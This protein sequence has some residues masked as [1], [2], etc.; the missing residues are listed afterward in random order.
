MKKF[1]LTLSSVALLATMNSCT[2]EEIIEDATP[3]VNDEALISFSDPVTISHGD[4][5]AEIDGTSLPTGGTLGIFAEKTA[6]ES[7]YITNKTLNGYATAT[8]SE[9]TGTPAYY[10]WPGSESLDFYAYFY[11]A[12]SSGITVTSATD[13]SYTLQSTWANQVDLLYTEKVTANRTTGS[14]VPLAFKHTMAW[15]RFNIKSSTNVGAVLNSVSFSADE[16]ATFSLKT[17]TFGTPENSVSLTLNDG[18][19]TT[20]D[21]SGTVS[22]AYVNSL[23]IPT[24]WTDKEVTVRINGATFDP[25]KISK[26]F[27]PGLVYTYT[28]DYTGTQI[29]FSEPTVTPWDKIAESAVDVPVQ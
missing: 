16:S 19:P 26:T 8:N 27:V 25:V 11:L 29:V 17:G 14:A 15:I 12:S 28:I 18:T 9:F 7:P 5:K 20:P 23:L 21:A 13:I 4:T 24:T 10:Y 2:N 22:T 1:L 3:R 6:D